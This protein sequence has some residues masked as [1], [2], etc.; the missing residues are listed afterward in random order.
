M[1]AQLLEKAYS[2]KPALGLLSLASKPTNQ[3]GWYQLLEDC[4]VSKQKLE[5]HFD[6]DKR[7][8]EAKACWAG[9]IALLLYQLR[10]YASLSWT[11]YGPI[12]RS[13]S[14]GLKC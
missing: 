13:Q 5:K 3:V 12:R 1:T 14:T 6:L 10:A 4:A 8:T 9:N 7:S 11:A 2:A